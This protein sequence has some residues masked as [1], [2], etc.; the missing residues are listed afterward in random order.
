MFVKTDMGASEPAKE[1]SAHVVVVGNEKGGSGKSTTAMHI[2]VAL[3][4]AGQRVATIDL[5]SRQG[6]FTHYVYNRRG[7]ALRT[8]LKLELPEHY[9]IGR[10]DSVRIDEN[11][12]TEFAGFA[13][14]INAIEHTH[15]F[16]VIDTP[17]A[18][19]YLTRLAHSMADTLVTPLNDSFVDFDVLA[20]VDPQTFAVTGTSHYAEMVREARRQRRIV[21]GKT[22]DWVV[23]RNRL[24]ML[25]SRNKR[26]VGESVNEL[27]RQLG[28]RFIDGFAERVIYREFFPRGLSALDDIDEETLGT[29]PSMS[30]ITARQEVETLLAALR[31]PLEQ[32]ALPR[33]QAR[34]AWTAPAELPLGD[35]R[36]L[37]EWRARN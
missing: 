21:D 26:L 11:E 7:W 10:G 14:A 18:E 31:L 33:E 37:A 16:I 8:G 13:E 27:A 22:I 15:D 32:N 28:F 17:G 5:D 36:F 4:K 35:D 12:A 6:S 24:S 3:L 2:A 29:R 19:S 1:D 20:S 23:V 25:G 30:H 9:R 34:P